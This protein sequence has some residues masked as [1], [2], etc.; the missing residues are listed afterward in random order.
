MT[1]ELLAELRPVLHR[2][3]A[4]MTGSIADG[5][6]VVQDT[7]ERALATLGT[8]EAPTT[9]GEL[10]RWL[11]RVA[12]NRAIDRARGAAIRSAAPLEDDHA[13]DHVAA[14]DALAAADAVRAAIARFLELP[15]VPRSCVIMKDVLG[16]SLDEIA[17]YTELSVA[18]VKAA[19]HRG[20][21]RLHELGGD[22]MREPPAGTP[23]PTLARYAALFNARDWDGVRAM[24][25]EDVALDVALR[26]RRTGR[27]DVGVYFTNYAASFADPARRLVPSWLDGREVLACYRG[28]QLEHVI[29]VAVAGVEVAAIRDFYHLPYIAR[30]ARFAT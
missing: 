15:P 28:D 7:L 21:A 9:P 19:L 18:A 16:H 26:I 6:D 8:P 3:C 10:K 2:Y 27:R 11:F 20:R 12:H 5:E 23:S 24:L 1:A 13:A 4:R 17:G 30:D 25:A 22:A 29:V 14:D